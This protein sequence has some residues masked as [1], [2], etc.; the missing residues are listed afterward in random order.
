MTHAGEQVFLADPGTLLST[1]HEVD[2]GMRVRL[3]LS[4]PTDNQRVRGFLD[5]LSP[6]TRHRRFFTSMP[7]VSETVVRHFTYFDP[8]KRLVVTAVTMIGGSE[9]IVGLADVA[10]LETGVA[11]L[12]VVVDDDLQGQGVGKLL[13]EVIASLAVRHGATH[14]RAELLEHNVAMLRL[15]ERLGRTV[16]TVEDGTSQVYTRLSAA[17]RRAA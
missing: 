9:E 6:E 5:G 14:L 4:R 12:A 16:R 3:R 7:T 15:M 10:L 13:T 8:R 2:N 1:L 17:A 11:E